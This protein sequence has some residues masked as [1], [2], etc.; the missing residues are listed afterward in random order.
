MGKSSLW[1][2]SRRFISLSLEYKSLFRIMSTMKTV[3]CSTRGM[4]LNDCCSPLS[5]TINPQSTYWYLLIDPFGSHSRPGS[6]FYQPSNPRLSPSTHH[7]HSTIFHFQLVQRRDKHLICVDGVGGDIDW[8]LDRRVHCDEGLFQR[9][10]FQPEW[11][12]Y[13]GLYDRWKAE[14]VKRTYLG[15]CCLKHRVTMAVVLWIMIGTT[16]V[17]IG[18]SVRKVRSHEQRVSA[19]LY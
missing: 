3:E 9:I 2:K 4:S 8:A 16:I 10:A 14:T 12:R 18:K 6:P 7:H 19:L 5:C 11:K 17:E 15:R 13:S 1:R